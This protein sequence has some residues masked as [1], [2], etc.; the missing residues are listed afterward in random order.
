MVA[1]NA[2]TRVGNEV[3]FSCDFNRRTSLIV[4]RLTVC[5]C[6]HIDGWK[7]RR[8]LLFRFILQGF[9]NAET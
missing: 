3:S 8:F 2:E 9:I 4:A 1:L 7:W 5:A 6:A